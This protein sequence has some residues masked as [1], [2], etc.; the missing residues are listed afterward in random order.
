MTLVTHKPLLKRNIKTLLAL[1]IRTNP[2]YSSEH[3]KDNVFVVAYAA[4]ASVPGH[5]S[6]KHDTNRCISFRLFTK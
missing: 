6:L 3:V 4:L 5:L 1:N 2:S